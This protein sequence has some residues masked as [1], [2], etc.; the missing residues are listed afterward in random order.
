MYKEQVQ[1]FL[2]K[3]S[4]K[5]KIIVI[6]GPTGSGKTAMSIDIAQYLNSEIISTDSRQIY[7]GMDIGTGK[8]TPEETQWVPHHMIDIVNPD[9]V[10]SVGDFKSNSFPIIERLHMEAKIPLLVWGTGLYIDSIIFDFELPGIPA[11]IE[12]RKELDRL[13]K[14]ELYRK[15]QEIDPDYALELHPNN[16]PYIE[17]AVEV[18]LLTGKS[19]TEFREEKKLQYDVLFLTPYT[20]NR[21]EL[22]DKIN[23]RVEMMFHSGLVEEVQGLIDQGF[24]AQD[25]WMNSIGYREFF[26][27]LSEEKDISDIISEVQQNSRNYAKRQLTWFRKYEKFIQKP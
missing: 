13:S 11:D 3:K 7:R 10:F 26:P 14:E 18:K 23:S 25:P 9:E 15:L 22:Y 6:Y 16:R 27:Y 21:E 24:S 12:L 20:W 5:Q 2:E 8:I 4:E 1:D 17:R 19:K